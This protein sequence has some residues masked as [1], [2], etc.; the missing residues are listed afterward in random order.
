MSLVVKGRGEEGVYCLGEEGV[1]CL[2]EEG[3]AC[4]GGRGDTEFGLGDTGSAGGGLFLDRGEVAK[5]VELA[6]GMGRGDVEAGL[7][8]VGK[9]GGVALKFGEAADEAGAVPDLWLDGLFKGTDDEFGLGDLGNGGGG[10]GE[11]CWGRGRVGILGGVVPKALGDDI[12]TEGEEEEPSEEIEFEEAVDGLGLALEGLRDD[13]VNDVTPAPVTAAA[14]VREDGEEDWRLYEV[15]ELLALLAER[16]LEEEA[17]KKKLKKSHVSISLD[18]MA[19][20][21]LCVVWQLLR[22][23]K[24]KVCHVTI[25]KHLATIN[26][27]FLLKQAPLGQIPYFKDLDEMS[28]RDNW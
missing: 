20:V 14:V 17:F 10:P 3:N 26:M 2:G 16:R 12:G 6:P 27:D 13:C 21:D 5:E 19:F 4:C 18:S 22:V 15:E 9:E 11:A 8:E 23:M 7:E 28:L 24:A 25:K 1:Y